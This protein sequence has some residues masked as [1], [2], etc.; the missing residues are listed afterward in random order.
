VTRPPAGAVEQ[1]NKIAAAHAVIIFVV[2]KI[3]EFWPEGAPKKGLPTDYYDRFVDGYLAKSMH[4]NFKSTESR[5][6]A[7][8]DFEAFSIRAK[9]CTT[10]RAMMDAPARV[11]NFPNSPRP[12][13]FCRP[14]TSTSSRC[15][16]ACGRRTSSPS[17]RPVWKSNLQPDFNVR[18]FECFDTSTSAVLRELDESNR[19]VQKSAESTSM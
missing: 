10:A 3:E 2:Q 5:P 1:A 12:P 9:D 13:L 14:S 7:A 8:L 17:P 11:Q 15:T 18:V 4:D 16:C 19:L 6:A